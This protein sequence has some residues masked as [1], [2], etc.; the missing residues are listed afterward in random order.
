MY[1]GDDWG[2]V[3]DIVLSTLVEIT[4]YTSFVFKQASHGGQPCWLMSGSGGY[5]IIGSALNR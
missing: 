4:I 5:G 1:Y 2:V 3:Y